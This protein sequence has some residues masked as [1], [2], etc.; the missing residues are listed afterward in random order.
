MLFGLVKSNININRFELQECV[1]LLRGVS[2]REELVGVA[3][4]RW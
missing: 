2:E 3:H 1:D 4:R